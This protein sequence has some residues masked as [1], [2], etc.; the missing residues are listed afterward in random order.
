VEPEKGISFEDWAGENAGYFPDRS[1][2]EIVTILEIWRDQAAAA[3]GIDD[4]E[5]AAPLQRH[6]T[7][8]GTGLPSN[9]ALLLTPGEA[10]AVKFDARNSHHPVEVAASQFGK[11]V[12]EWPR[13]ELTVSDVERGKLASGLTLSV[14]DGR[15]IPCRTPRLAGNPA[16][17]ILITTLGAELPT[18]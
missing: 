16:A 17:A 10:I 12:G 15:A 9:F 4:L 11:R 6:L 8:R 1:G 2:A 14:G 5:L 13:A 3:A 18:V 7:A